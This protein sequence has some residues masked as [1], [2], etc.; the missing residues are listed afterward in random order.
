M[1]GTT[2]R[3]G[4]GSKQ[5]QA[6]SAEADVVPKHLEDSPRFTSGSAK[7]EAVGRGAGSTVNNLPKT[8]LLVILFL[9][10]TVFAVQ[11]A[12]EEVRAVVI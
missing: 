11:M 5:R 6:A 1:L 7:A 12:R 4:G 10:G 2:S 3:R 9:V 8:V